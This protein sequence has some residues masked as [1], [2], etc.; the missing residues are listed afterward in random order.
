[1]PGVCWG[2]ERVITHMLADQHYKFNGKERDPETGFDDFGARFYASAW[3]RWLTPDWWR[4]WFV[5][6][7]GLLVTSSP[8]S[9]RGE[10]AAHQAVTRWLV[11]MVGFAVTQ[12][13]EL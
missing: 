12:R 8:S 11:V 5:D 9:A 3:G 2:G 7:A 1:V 6:G 4:R 13:G 10:E